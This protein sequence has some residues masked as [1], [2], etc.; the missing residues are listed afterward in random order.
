MMSLDFKMRLRAAFSKFAGPPMMFVAFVAM[1]VRTG[2]S[3][4]A[5]RLEVWRRAVAA[6]L[7]RRVRYCCTGRVPSLMLSPSQ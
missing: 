2:L 4:T 3:P 5:V 6:L 1:Q 7:A